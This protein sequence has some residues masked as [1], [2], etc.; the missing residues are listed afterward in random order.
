MRRK[1]FTIIELLVVVSIIALLIGILLPAIG[2]ARDQAKLTISFTNLKNLATAHANYGAEWNDRQLTYVDDNLGRRGTSSSQAFMS[3]YWEGPTNG[4]AGMHPPLI[5]GWGYLQRSTGEYVYL[6]YR[7]GGNDG[8]NGL[9]V[10]IRFGPPSYGLYFGAF[11]IPNG[12]QFNQYVSGRFY[13]KTFYAPK[14]VVAW[15]TLE[16]ENCF[17]APDEFPDCLAPVPG[18]GD[19]PGWSS[20]CLSPAAMFSPTVMQR[21]DPDNP[22]S[23]FRFPWTD[24]GPA[25]FRSP[26]FSQCSYPSLKTHMLEH[27]W[28][29]NRKQDCNPNFDVSV[30]G[31]NC[32]PYY[33]NASW[34]S[35]PVALFYDGHV[36]SIGVRRAQRQSLRAQEQTG[37]TGVVGTGLWHDGTPFGADGYLHQYAYETQAAT[38]F[39]VLTTDGIRGRDINSD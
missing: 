13:D 18:W 19:A 15:N 29:Q 12:Y 31:G 14:D 39:H 30:F 9:L 10:P 17:S 36:E 3:Y 5:L 6:A 7:P 2:K 28:L 22:G 26:A 38:S 34:D 1:A 11:R 16:Q 27:N 8:N 24:G 37:T 35:S 25:A 32:E 20:Y 4:E 33:F 21:A 23:G